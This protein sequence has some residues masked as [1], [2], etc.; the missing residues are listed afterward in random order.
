M[1]CIFQARSGSNCTP[2][3]DL[4][5]PIEPFARTYPFAYRFKEIPDLAR[6]I[7]RLYADPER[8]IDVWARDHLGGGTPVDTL[9]LLGRLTTATRDA[10]TYENRY[11]PG[12]RTPVELLSVGAGTC[13]DLALFLMEAVRAL[14][15]AARFVTGYLYDP[16]GDAAGAGATHA[17]VQV[18]LPGAGWIE[19]DPTN[20]TIGAGN[21]IRVAV[22]RDP[23]QAIPLC[24]TY[25]G[26]PDDFVA[27]DVEVHVGYE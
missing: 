25:E 19:L 1:R 27:M 21:L 23:A 16:A 5:F 20:A 24:G 4:A 14:G 2:P 13:R 17:W 22:A 15:L 9:A 26:A 18:Y 10:F 7:E 6:N 3:P 12:T 8:R 11:E